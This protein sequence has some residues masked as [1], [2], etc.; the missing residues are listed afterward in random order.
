MSGHLVSKLNNRQL[1]QIFLLP[2]IPSLVLS[3]CFVSVC[4]KKILVSF[5]P[6]PIGPDIFWIGQS[7]V[8]ALVLF[9]LLYGIYYIAA[10]ISY[11]QRGK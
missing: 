3:I 8:I 6:L 4:A 11:G 5:F 1:S 9:L 7:L 10:R 2:L